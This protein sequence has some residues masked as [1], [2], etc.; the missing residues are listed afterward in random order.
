M[1]IF[2][3]MRYFLALFSIYLSLKSTCVM[4]TKRQKETKFPPSWG[5]LNSN[6]STQK[7]LQYV[8]VKL[9]K[10]KDKG[11]CK[12]YMAIPSE[13]LSTQYRLLVMQLDIKNKL[14]EG[15]INDLPSIKQGSLTMASSLEMREK[16]MDM[17]FQESSRDV[18]NICHNTVSH[19]RETTIEVLG[20]IGSQSSRHRGDLW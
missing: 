1:D 13:N 20:V 11:L 17:G 3:C 8:E 12:Y 6:P 5:S 2:L 18:G 14:K 19:I 15:V 16:L 4:S 7:L 9:L 10:K